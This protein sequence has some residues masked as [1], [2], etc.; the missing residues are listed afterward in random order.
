M[1]LVISAILCILLMS[2][3]ACHKTT[4]GFLDVE[5]A[6]YAIDSMVVKI[7]LDTTAPVEMPNP[8]YYQLLNLGFTPDALATF[9]IYP[10]IKQ[11]GGV[12]YDRNRLDIPWASTAIEGVFGTMPVRVTVS[13]ITNESGGA[14]K[15]KNIIS[16]RS[17]GIVSVPLHNDL[18]AGYYHLSLT[19]SNEGYTKKLEN[20]FTII[21]K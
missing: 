6:S 9:G 16:I 21:V 18:P 13:G 2:A 5:K 3:A 20:A 12:D 4:I 15:L 11:S 8:T 19:F 10:T 17:N 1:K 14:D 7:K